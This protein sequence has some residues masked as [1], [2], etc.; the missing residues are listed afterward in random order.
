[1]LDHG[2]TAH[3]VDFVGLKKQ[4]GLD[5]YGCIRLINFIRTHA[6]QGGVAAVLSAVSAGPAAWADEKWLKPVLQD[7]ALLFNIDEMSGGD[8]EDEEK[9]QEG[10]AGR[11]LVLEN[12]VLQSNIEDLQAQLSQMAGMLSRAGVSM[13]SGDAV[14]VAAPAKAEADGKKKKKVDANDGYYFD[15]YSNRSIHE[16]MLKDVVRTEAYR[17][18]MYK[19]PELFKDK[20]VLDIGCG[21][22]ILSMF[23]AKAGARRVVGIDA[24]DIIDK[25][26]E[27]VKANG[28][29]K[30]ITLVKSKVEEAE[31]PAGVDK[32]DIIISEWMGYFLLFESMLPS[33]LFGRDKWMA[34]DGGVYPNKSM[35][36]VAG[37]ETNQLKKE[38]VD[39][40]PN[41]YGFDMSVLIEEEE[42]FPGSTVEVVDPRTIM[43]STSELAA[44]DIMT[45]KDAELDFESNFTLNFERDD[46]FSGFLTWFDVDFDHGCS[47]PINMDTSPRTTPTH[48]KQTLFHL[49]KGLT[50]KAGDS[51]TCHMVASRGK[52]N[53]REY[54]VTVRYRLNRKGEEVTPLPAAASAAA[55][56]ADDYGVVF[57]RDWC[58]AA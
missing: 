5:F 21:T 56:G 58:V 14:M 7:D 48:W 35:M 9:A 39:F 50:V 42:K 25:T 29:D 24:A 46:V 8:G 38:T 33:V 43:S 6:A 37:V 15:G 36:Y 32:V 52:V 3:G 34:K 12:Q 53:T 28:L 1:M 17:D 47:T 27:I 22:G 20:V 26:R 10:G 16:T 18:F 57:V 55:E 13:I 44:F 49:S 31:L 11:D 41:V 30:V 54:D 2:S 23:A 51:V 19:N 45:I 40:W 4:H